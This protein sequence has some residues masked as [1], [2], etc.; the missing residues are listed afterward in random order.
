MRRILD[1]HVHIWH[2]K[3]ELGVFADMEKVRYALGIDD[4][5]N[6]EESG[7][8]EGEE[9]EEREGVVYTCAVWVGEREV[10]RVGGGVSKEEVKTKA[11]ERAV[12]ILKRERG[13]GVCG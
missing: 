9:E 2:P 7:A 13:R 11:A 1:Q 6:E 12:G 8:E 10:V 5:P 3:E 4:R